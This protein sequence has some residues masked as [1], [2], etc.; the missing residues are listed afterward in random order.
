[1][2]KD[3]VPV[4]HTNEEISIFIRDL[5][6]P[7]FSLAVAKA[8]HAYLSIGDKDSQQLKEKIKLL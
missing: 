3:L 4:R 6:S 1:M 2:E 8:L 5:M 7:S